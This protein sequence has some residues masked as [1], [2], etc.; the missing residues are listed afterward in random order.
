MTNEPLYPA[1]RGQDEPR[2]QPRDRNDQS[3]FGMGSSAQHAVDSAALSAAMDRA[4]ENRVNMV[5]FANGLL[6]GP[7]R[8]G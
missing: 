1:G 8:K 5:D 7:T 2:K 3:D 4:E 6:A